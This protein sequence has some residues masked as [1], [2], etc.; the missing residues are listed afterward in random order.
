ML[1]LSRK[2]QEKIRI[3]NDI[4]ITVLRMKGK[5]VRLGIEAPGEVPV[6]RGELVFDQ[7]AD[8]GE[9]PGFVVRH[10]G[11]GYADNRMAGQFDA[12]AKL[13]R[14][15]QSRVNARGRS[16]HEIELVDLLPHR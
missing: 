4:V 11:I 15:F 13:I 16:H 3:G 10:R 9:M 1:V 12:I 14:L 5:A 7:T 6:L 2:Q 8:A